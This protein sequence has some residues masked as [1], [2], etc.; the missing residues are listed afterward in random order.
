M[1][2]GEITSPGRHS[3]GNGSI[4]WVPIA[5]LPATIAETEPS[6]EFRLANGS[7][8]LIT[9]RKDGVTLVFVAN[10][11]AEPQADVITFSGDRRLTEVWPVGTSSYR[12]HRISDR[13]SALHRSH[14]A[15]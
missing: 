2:I 12:Q 4:T 8:P 14:L 11:T 7:L 13:T 6:P 15:G 5:N 9:Q 1:L 10:P 3:V